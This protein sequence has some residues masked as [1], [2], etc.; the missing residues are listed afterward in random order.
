MSKA[1][2]MQVFTLRAYGQTSTFRASSVEELARRLYRRSHWTKAECMRLA[3]D[4]ARGLVVSA[5]D[6][7]ML[8]LPGRFDV[9]EDRPDERS[10]GTL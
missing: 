5:P 2:M 9:L 1:S 10:G 8:V 7:D 4:L 6:F 3:S